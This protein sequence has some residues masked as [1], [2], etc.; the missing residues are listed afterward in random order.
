MEYY[1]KVTTKTKEEFIYKVE[2]SHDD[3]FLDLVFEFNQAGLT[4]T[5]SDKKTYEDLAEVAI[6]HERSLKN[7]EKEFLKLNRIEV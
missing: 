7:K 1:I 4:V 6:V 2:A 5:P 3:L